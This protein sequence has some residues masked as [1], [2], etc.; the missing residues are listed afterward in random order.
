MCGVL[1]DIGPKCMRLKLL[2][3]LST[4]KF[5]RLMSRVSIELQ[6]NV[7]ETVSAS[8][9]TVDLSLRNV[10]LLLQL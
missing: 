8:I 1:L 3:R 5:Y 7:S 10:G 6:S 9:I 4:L 2:R